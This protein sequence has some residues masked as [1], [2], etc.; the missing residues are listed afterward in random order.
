MLQLN[1][2]ALPT[3]LAFKHVAVSFG[4]IMPVSALGAS[5]PQAKFLHKLQDLQT[6]MVERVTKTHGAVARRSRRCG[7][8]ATAFGRTRRC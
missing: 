7:T 2:F 3:T 6:R 1:S 8:H 5:H 4:D